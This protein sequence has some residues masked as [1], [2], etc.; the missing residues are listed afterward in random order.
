MR[1]PPTTSTPRAA[2]AGRSGS[3][4]ADQATDDGAAG[5]QRADGAALAPVAPRPGTD[6][7]TFMRKVLPVD[8]AGGPVATVVQ[9]LDHPCGAGA[10]AAR[11]RPSVAA[12]W[13]VRRAG[14]LPTCLPGCL[15]PRSGP[16]RRVGRLSWEECAVAVI[17]DGASRTAW[18]RLRV[19]EL[20]NPGRAPRWTQIDW[21]DPAGPR[22]PG[23]SLVAG[24]LY[25]SPR[26]LTTSAIPYRSGV[27]DIVDFLDHQLVSAAA[28][29]AHRG[30]A[31]EPRPVADY[32][33]DDAS[34]ERAGDR[35]KDPGV[36]QR[37]GPGDPVRRRRP[38][39]FLR[40]EGRAALLAHRCSPTGCWG[41]PLVLRRQG[42]PGAGAPWTWPE[43]LGRAAPPHPG[44]APNCGD[45]V[46]VAFRELSSCG[47][48][49]GGGEEEACLA[50]PEPD[51]FAEPPGHPGRR[52]LQP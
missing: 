37:G 25:V 38:A 45:W 32:S 47:F 41:D 48:W 49:P 46:M 9:P 26:G 14:D 31:L 42:E 22:A 23:Q 15:I 12:R 4:V 18:P 40:P 7:S 52:V 33:R 29:G 5:Q 2:A 11:G 10:P 50:Y 20:D 3:R 16:R 17:S 6:W 30:V 24:H 44:G 1:S 51:G 13:P 35:D 43:V 34:P 8:G 19:A 21:R 27:F 36:S 28:T 39:H